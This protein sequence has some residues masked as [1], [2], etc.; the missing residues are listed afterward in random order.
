MRWQRRCSE[1]YW[2]ALTASSVRIWS[3]M[4]SSGTHFRKDCRVR[5]SPVQSHFWQVCRKKC[6]ARPSIVIVLPDFRRLQSQ[7]TRS[8]RSEEHTSELQ[9]RSDLVCRLLLETEQPI[10]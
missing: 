5:T 7:Q 6:R 2:T 1:V 8:R 10:V 3:K 4:S 9:S